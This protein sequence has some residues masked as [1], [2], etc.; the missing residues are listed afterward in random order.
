[1]MMGNERGAGQ[2]RRAPPESGAGPERRVLKVAIVDDSLEVQDSLGRLLEAVAG[3]EIV[4]CAEDKASALQLIEAT[5]PDVLVLDVD[6]RGGDRGF[7]VLR[8]VVRHHPGTRVVA[9]SNFSWEAM[10]E[11]FLQAGAEAY[12]D[13][14]LQF[15]RVID[16]VRR[17]VAQTQS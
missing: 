6:L 10:R 12:F 1:M 15:N 5:R 8:H 9:L 2:D 7:D 17:A 3:V 14:A 13:K 11:G 4:G 16:W